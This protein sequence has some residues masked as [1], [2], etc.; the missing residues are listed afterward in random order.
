MC[1]KLMEV[2]VVVVVQVN[3]VGF[4]KEAGDL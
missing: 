2:K 3:E 1:G 4:C